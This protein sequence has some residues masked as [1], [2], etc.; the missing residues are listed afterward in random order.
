MKRTKETNIINYF[1]LI[2]VIEGV[3]DVSTYNLTHPD[4]FTFENLFKTNSD[5]TAIDGHFI[6]NA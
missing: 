4:K 3:T 2:N 5:Y 1:V 6:D